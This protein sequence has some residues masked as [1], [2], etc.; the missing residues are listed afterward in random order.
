MSKMKRA[1]LLGVYA[2]LAATSNFM[3]ESEAAV[4]SMTD[5]ELEEAID[6]NKKQCE[7]AKRLRY[8]MTEYF[9]GISSVFARNQKNADR[10]AR[11]KGYL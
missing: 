1:N 9:Y 11:S 2:M 7:T 10:N 4:H 5:K 6:R 3:N 8:G